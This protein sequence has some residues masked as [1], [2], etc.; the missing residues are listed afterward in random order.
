MEKKNLKVIFFD[1]D[2]TLLPMDERF[3]KRYFSLLVK[4]LAPLGYAPENVI[5]SVWAGINSMIANNGEK[6][7]EQAF[8]D[9]YAQINGE[10]SRADEKHFKEFYENDFDGIKEV[11]GFDPCAKGIIKD[12]KDSGYRLILATNPIFP[13]IATEKRIRW[14]G[15]EPSDFEIV[16]TYEDSRFCKPN[17][18]YFETLC[19][20]LNVSPEE[21]LMVGNDVDDDMPAEK[22]GMKVFLLIDCL[23]NGEGKDLSIY[24]QGNLEDLMKFI[25]NL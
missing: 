15:L 21:C 8:W 12:L 25:K 7:N 20:M 5:K 2:G 9:T 19:E 3:D 13:R 17:L 22:L 16:T 18:K 11:C 6:S 24:P 10:S 23:L 4:R 1:L 14:A